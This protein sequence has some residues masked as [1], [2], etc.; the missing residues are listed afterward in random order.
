MTLSRYGTTFDLLRQACSEDWHAYTHHPFVE[1][2]GDGTLSQQSYLHYLAQD[3]VFLVHFARAWALGVVKAETPNEMKVCA[4]TVDV[5]I[6]NEM[7]LHVETCKRAGISEPELFACKEEVENLAYTRYV[8]DCGM[9]GDLL[10]LLIALAPCCFG[11]GEIGMRLVR[12]CAPD[13]PYRSWIDTYADDEYQAALQSIGGMLDD[14]V[15]RRL[16]SDPKEN[17]RWPQLVKRFE[18]ATHLEVAFWGMGLRG[19]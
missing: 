12:G 15:S 13:T 6:N 17:C 5:L 4:R 8:I 1:Q 7:A 2:L 10:D 19:R 11:Y 18:V 9:Q 14:A 16:G 3:Y